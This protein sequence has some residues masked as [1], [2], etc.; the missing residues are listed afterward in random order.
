MAEANFGKMTSMHFYAWKKGLKTGQYYLR[1]RPSRD[2]IKFTVNIEQLLQATDSGNNEEILKCLNLANQNKD[3][4]NLAGLAAGQDP[5]R[6]DRYE[7]ISKGT[8]EDGNGQFKQEMDPSRYNA[9][10]VEEVVFECIN[11]SG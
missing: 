6:E 2:A 11:C 5:K 9:Q 10:E 7:S 8:E 1:T 4:E 3:K